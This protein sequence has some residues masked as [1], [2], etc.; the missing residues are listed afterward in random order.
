M[1]FWKKLG[2]YF[3]NHAET[4]DHHFEKTL[5]TRYYRTTKDKGLK[6]LENLF[7]NSQTYE[8]N[9]ISQNHGE[10]SV[11][12]T[13]GRKAFIVATVIM[14]RPHQ[15][16]IDFAFTTESIFP[17]DFGFSTREIQKLYELVNKDLILIE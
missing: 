3:T 4:R 16:A 10:I 6:A 7:E 15:T 17:F 13:R 2:K 11:L 9:S 1:S 5:R 14:V 12:K 8:M